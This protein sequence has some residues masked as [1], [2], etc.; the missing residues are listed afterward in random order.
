MP[1]KPQIRGATDSQMFRAWTSWCANCA[2]KKP[3]RYSTT[4]TS[5]LKTHVESNHSATSTATAAPIASESQAP[6]KKK[7]KLT[8]DTVFSVMMKAGAAKKDWQVPPDFRMAPSMLDASDTADGY[9]MTDIL[10][11][12]LPGQDKA[13]QLDNSA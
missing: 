12:Q 11:T 8:T 4:T 13:A 5:K 3:A 2:K 10:K 9:N 6:P 1:P 7:I